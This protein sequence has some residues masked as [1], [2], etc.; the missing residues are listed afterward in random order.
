M[1]RR[2]FIVAI[3]ILLAVTASVFAQEVPVVGIANVTFKVSDLSK[4][5][6]YYEGVLGMTKAFEIKDGSG[7]TTSVF[8]KVNDDQF[9][10][11]TPTPKPGELIRQA[12]VAFQSSDLDKLMHQSGSA[13]AVMESSVSGLTKKLP[14]VLLMTTYCFPLRPI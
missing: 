3:S 1:F 12:R 14:P 8:F 2:S 7:K 6:A 10:E 13:K 4:A 11:V 5:R 9:I